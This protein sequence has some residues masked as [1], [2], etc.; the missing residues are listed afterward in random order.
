MDLFEDELRGE[1]VVAFCDKLSTHMR[2]VVSSLRRWGDTLSAKL[3][4]YCGDTE[5]DDG[6]GGFFACMLISS[7]FSRPG[8]RFVFI[9]F[10]LLVFF[11]SM[12]VITYKLITYWHLVRNL[13]TLL[14]SAS[15]AQTVSLTTTPASV[16][17]ISWK[18]FAKVPAIKW[19]LP[20]ISRLIFFQSLFKYVWCHKTESFNCVSL[21]KNFYCLTLTKYV[22][23]LNKVAK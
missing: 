11:T 10:V 9:A 21:T 22:Y 7:S 2:Y 1:A 6:C 15:K 14:Q 3:R 12:L 19:S 4:F 13:M 18:M 20:C 23:C 16:S 5:A 17:I 8:K